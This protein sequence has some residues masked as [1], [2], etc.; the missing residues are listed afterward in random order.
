MNEAA[1]RHANFMVQQ[2]GLDDG[3]VRDRV[4]DNLF[5]DVEIEVGTGT[6][7]GDDGLCRHPD[8]TFRLASV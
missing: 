3:A 2:G 6:A 5:T 8:G 4:R 7:G 1:S